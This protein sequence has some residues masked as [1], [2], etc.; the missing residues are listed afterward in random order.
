MKRFS[1]FCVIWELACL[2]A[3]LD[4]RMLRINKRIINGNSARDAQFPWHVSIIGKYATG[5]QLLCGGSLISHEW[6]L[7]AAHCVL[8]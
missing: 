1:I 6:V 7:T 5:S 3:C 2:A 8:G 4:A